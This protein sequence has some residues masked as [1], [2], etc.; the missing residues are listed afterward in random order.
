MLELRPQV[1]LV[2]PAWHQTV[3]QQLRAT[4]KLQ[5]HSKF[6]NTQSQS[7][8]A[9]RIKSNPF[10]FQIRKLRPGEAAYFLPKVPQ[11]QR[12]RPERCPP[13]LP[14]SEMRDELLAG[15]FS[16]GH[17]TRTSGRNVLFSNKHTFVRPSCSATRLQPKAAFN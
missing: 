10:N 16:Q 15:R 9:V 11:R 13:P 5:S 12:Q 14:S 7:G 3:Q 8:R 17:Q 6:L 4:P 1:I 2:Q